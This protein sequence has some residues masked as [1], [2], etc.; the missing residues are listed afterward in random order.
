MD[1]AMCGSARC[2]YSRCNVY[3][4][5]GDRLIQTFENVAGISCNVTRRYLY[6]GSRDSTTGWYSKNYDVEITVKGAFIPRA[7]SH[8]A[9]M[10]GTYVKLDAILFTVDVL[11]E[12]EEIET[13][14]GV[15]YEVKTVKLHY[16]V[17]GDSFS[18]RECGLTL[19]PLH[20]LS[21]AD[22]TPSVEDARA[23]TKTYWE[24]YLSQANLNSH[25]FIVCYSDA[26]YSIIRV[27]TTKAVHIV[28]ALGQPESTPLM[29]HDQTPYGYEEHIPTHVL[30]L[31][32]KLQWLA[33]AELRRI[34]EAY[35]LG[36]RRSL[37]RVR[38]TVH[39]FG[40]TKVYD[41]EF[42]LNYR[43]DTT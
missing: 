34:V 33:E 25:S 37:E 12:D 18:H 3:R 1:A 30:T 41:T 10:A 24:T 21:Y 43:R 23:R 40:S 6:L 22:T 13:E 28:F 11:K 2:D 17:G 42:V 26:D 7:A 16:A 36:S 31:D 35:P 14:S 32:T 38:S 15:F 29:G 5:D 4:D 39:D 8:L 27:F 9:T 19:L 20:E